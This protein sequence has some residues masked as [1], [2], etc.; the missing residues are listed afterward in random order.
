MKNACDSLRK[1][2]LV[3]NARYRCRHVNVLLV[4]G[5]VVEMTYIRGSSYSLY[6]EFPRKSFFP[7][8]MEYTNLYRYVLLLLPYPPTYMPPFPA[9]LRA[10]E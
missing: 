2:E 10:E 6:L 7:S 5:F 9:L 1:H 8:R 4:S 3:I